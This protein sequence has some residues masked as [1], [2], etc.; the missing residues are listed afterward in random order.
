MKL[1]KLFAIL[2][3]ITISQIL[4]IQITATGDGGKK[5][6]KIGNGKPQIISPWAKPA[7]SPA[8]SKVGSFASFTNPNSALQLN[9][10]DLCFIELEAQ[11][12]CLKKSRSETYVHFTE[13]F[14][15]KT[16]IPIASEAKWADLYNQ[17]HI[18]ESILPAIIGS[19]NFKTEP[20][21]LITGTEES[22][23]NENAAYLDRLSK[24]G[25]SSAGDVKDALEVAPKTLEHMQG[26]ATSAL[27]AGVG[28]AQTG[29]G[30]LGMAIK[31][32]TMLSAHKSMMAH[33]VKDASTPKVEDNK[34]CVGSL[35]QF[36]KENDCG[37]RRKY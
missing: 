29:I 14:Q 13:L 18:F 19:L 10:D 7:G 34:R 23:W 32:F 25:E 24:I 33:T 36:R 27:D 5:K 1:I 20:L 3:I 9:Q 4:S 22:R 15:K 16:D 11:K 2:M 6:N 37:G 21:I 26:Q 30:I 31:E 12:Y 28:A 35:N 17:K 8:T